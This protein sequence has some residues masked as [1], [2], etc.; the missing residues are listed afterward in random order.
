MHR[1]NLIV[2]TTVIYSFIVALC[3]N[4]MFIDG[5]GYAEYPG[6]C[7]K[8]VQCYQYQQRVVAVQRECP[9]GYF[10]HQ[11]QVLCRPPAEVPCYDGKYYK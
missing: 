9:Y 7:D 3:G 1:K 11:D 6:Y 5:I 10:W 4:S 8:L 2:T